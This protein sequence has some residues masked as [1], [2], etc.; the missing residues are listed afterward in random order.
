MIITP[1][2]TTKFIQ[3]FLVLRDYFHAPFNIIHSVKLRCGNFR[4]YLS[5]V[6][7]VKAPLRVK[8]HGR[9]IFLILSTCMEMELIKTNQSLERQVRC[10]PS[11][12][13][14]FFSRKGRI[15]THSTL[16]NLTTSFLCLTT[17]ENISI[18][19]LLVLCEYMSTMKFHR[20][21]GVSDN[22][23]TINSIVGK[24]VFD[25]IHL[26][27]VKVKGPFHMKFHVIKHIIICSGVLFFSNP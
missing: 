15:H 3:S 6:S 16:F 22:F 18:I 20:G 14:I 11:L 19:S 25:I 12:F 7:K 26:N 23:H 21:V 13:V 17:S 8:F 27:Y 24:T 4:Y 1:I 9:I 5:A 2:Y 10:F